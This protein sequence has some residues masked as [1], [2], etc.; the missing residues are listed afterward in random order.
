MRRDITQVFHVFVSVTA[1]LTPLQQVI[2]QC[3]L[4][5]DLELFEV[6]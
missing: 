1:V 4:E 6:L 3:A 5:R 2:A